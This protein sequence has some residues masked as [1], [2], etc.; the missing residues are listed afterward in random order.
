MPSRKSALSIALLL[1]AG[2][3]FAPISV[4]AQCRLCESPTTAAGT[5][6]SSGEITLQ[7]EAALDF[8]RLVLLDG[9][10]GSA[11]LRPD[12][13]RQV[14]GAVGAISSRAMVGSARVRG[15]P[16]K[17]VRIDLPKRIDLHSLSGGSVSIDDLVSDLP[18]QPRLDSAGL[19]TFRFG[20]RL[21]VTGNS[22]GDYRGD[23]P[24]TVE[25]P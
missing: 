17:S 24:I 2:S 15:E 8:D 3:S 12:G 13:S 10:D 9:G 14:S 25:Y 22:E 18:A 23:I 5:E 16:G 4:Q 20:G 6:T 11:E 21:R 1:A 19:L 7:I